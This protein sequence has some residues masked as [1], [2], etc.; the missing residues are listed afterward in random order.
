VTEFVNRNRPIGIAIVAVFAIIA[1]L[2]EIVVGFTGSYLGILSKSIPPAF[3]TVIVG[4]FY[5]LGALTRFR[6]LFEIDNCTTI[7][8]EW[9]SYSAGKSSS[10]ATATNCYR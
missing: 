1:S 10:V 3:S 6:V 2:G 7:W 5:S 4:A 9:R 8:L